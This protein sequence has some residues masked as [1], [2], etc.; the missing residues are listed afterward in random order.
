MNFFQDI[1]DNVQLNGQTVSYESVLVKQLILNNGQFLAEET[2]QLV[3]C[4]TDQSKNKFSI[5]LQKLF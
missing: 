2:V 3:D 4:K 5:Q 1:P